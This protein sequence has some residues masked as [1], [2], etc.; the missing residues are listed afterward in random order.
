M[1]APQSVVNIAIRAI[2][3]TKA[4]F[5]TP[6]RNAKDLAAAMRKLAPAAAVA[7]T[8]IAAAFGVAV[9]KLVDLRQ[10]MA[11]FS[12]RIGISIEELSR[13][14]FAADQNGVSFSTLQMAL[15]RMTRRTAEAAKGTGEAVKALD[16]LGISAM[17]ISKLAPDQQ[18]YEIARAFDAIQNPG[19]RAAIAMKL[20]D[21][22]GVK[23]LQML[24]GGSEGLREMTQEAD[25]LGL[26]IST[27]SAKAVQTF[28]YNLGLLKGGL[29]GVV[30]QFVN[31]LFP[32]LTELNKEE[33]VQGFKNLK[34]EAYAFGET[35][36]DLIRPFLIFY[37][38]LKFI[39]SSIG[40]LFDSLRVY[41]LTEFVMAIEDTFKRTNKV[42]AFFSNPKN[43]INP[44]AWQDLLGEINKSFFDGLNNSFENFKSTVADLRFDI[45]KI[46]DDAAEAGAAIILLGEKSKGATSFGG[47]VTGVIP[48]D[49]TPTNTGFDDQPIDR[50]A[51]LAMAGLPSQETLMEF[52]QR[53]TEQMNNIQQIGIETFTGIESAMSSAF[54]GIIDG[55]QSAGEAFKRMGQNMLSV[56]ASVIARLIVANILVKAL[57]FFGF[58]AASTATVSGGIG[59]TGI[60]D[61]ASFA[62]MAHNGLSR[63][64]RE[65]TYILDEGERVLS[66]RQNADLV[67]FMESG[68]NRPVNIM[69][70]GSVLART[71]TNLSDRGLIEIRPSVVI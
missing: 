35:V 31:G 24:A 47:S 6:I 46:S 51:G 28:N 9:T 49:I 30:N 5:T 66:A 62:G 42:I 14:R 55:T 29:I 10:Q 37:E 23:V 54:A 3:Q 64:P 61:M 21:S 39:L 8:A 2:D 12:E 45:K 11:E 53:Y 25:D 13:L 60:L 70:D 15:Q 38:S 68:G 63:V 48:D 69:L 50:T 58:G 71:M 43:L 36:A 59:G 67:E 65:G 27:E 56:I 22:E 40:T 44:Q 7:G 19:Q 52:A 57:G 4:G 17:A 33:A 18:F 20:F 16:E 41:I 1:A 32:N 26:T 34:D